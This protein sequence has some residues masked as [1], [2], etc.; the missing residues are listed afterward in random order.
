MMITSKHAF[1]SNL[2]YTCMVGMGDITAVEWRLRKLARVP[3]REHG[4]VTLVR[5]RRISI[6]L[7]L[8]LCPLCTWLFSWHLSGRC[9]LGEGVA[10]PWAIRLS[11]RHGIWFQAVREGS[12]PRRSDSTYGTGWVLVSRNDRTYPLFRTRQSEEGMAP[13]LIE[14]LSTLHGVKQDCCIPTLLPIFTRQARHNSVGV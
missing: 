8:T 1:L 4:H 10:V 14:K 7:S 9:T 6:P 13:C 12:C 2:V 3:R 11:R 5:T